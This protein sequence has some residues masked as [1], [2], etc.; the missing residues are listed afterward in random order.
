MN[1][2][3]K[4]KISFCSDKNS[5]MNSF[6][7]QWIVDLKNQKYNVKWSH[8]FEDVLDANVCFILG[9]EKIIPKNLL[10]QNQHNLVVHESNLPKGRGWSPLT[11]QI[12]EGK[13][14]VAVTL[15]EASEKV[16]AGSIYLQDHIFLN[17]TELLD[18]LRNK[19]AEITFK[20]C[21]SFLKLYPSI[22]NEKKKQKGKVTFYEKRSPADS[23]LNVNLSL[24]EQFNLL[25]VCDNDK[26]PAWFEIKGKKYI[27]RV[28]KD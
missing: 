10:K 3:K 11:W 23:Q 18:E 27:L 6:I 21:S 25:R 22:I 20:L 5:W 26:Y 4:N 7:S 1:S 24:K 14:K 8:R 13:R 17:G 19:Q 2:L 16:D 12:L 28:Y 15:F 9:Y